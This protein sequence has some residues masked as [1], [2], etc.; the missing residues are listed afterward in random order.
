M[1]SADVNGAKLEFELKGSGEPVLLISPVLADG[2]R[3]FL[4]EPAFTGRYQ[5]ILYH[6]R[7]WAGSTHRPGPVSIAE[8]AADAAALLAKLDIAQAHIAGHSSGAAIALQ[9]ALDH[10]ACVHSL[11]LLEPTLLTVPGA[12]GFFEKVGPA[13]NAFGAGD[14]ESAVALFLS[15]ASGLDWPTCRSVIETH[16]P[17][18]VAQTVRDAQT[19]FGIELPSLQTWAFGPEHA[20]AISQPVLS[21]VASETEQLWLDVAAALRTWMPQVEE[22]TINGIGHLLHLQSTRPVAAAVAEFLARHPLSGSS[23]VTRKVEE[24]PALGDS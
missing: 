23:A 2:F 22:C 6:R 7:G 20:A 16:A 8:H 21:V 15:A 19:F 4:S 14:H 9:L 24:V 11:A 3:P 10:P 1:K 13:L 12:Q 18:T 5:L 17:G